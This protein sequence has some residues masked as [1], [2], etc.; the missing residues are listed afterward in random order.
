[1][2]LFSYSGHGLFGP[3]LP[4][5]TTCTGGS[6]GAERTSAREQHTS[7]ELAGVRTNI[8]RGLLTGSDPGV[9]TCGA[10]GSTGVAEGRRGR[11]GASFHGM[12][13]RRPDKAMTRDRLSLSVIVAMSCCLLLAGCGAGDSAGT[14]LSSAH[15]TTTTTTMP[16][17]PPAHCCQAPDD[18]RRRRLA[19]G[20]PRPRPRV[21]D[22]LQPPCAH[23]A[24]LARRQRARPS[25]TSTTGLRSS[26]VRLSEYHPQV[27]TIL[28]GGN[29]AQNFLVDNEPVVFGTA[30]WH[31][32]YSQ[33]VAL[34]MKETLKAGAKMLWV[35]LPIMQ[36]P[37]P[38]RPPC[39]CSA[40]DLQGTG[41]GRHPGV[42]F[43]PDL[44]ALL[45][46]PGS[47][48]RLPHQQLRPDGARTGL[49]TASTSPRRAAA[50]SS[51]SRR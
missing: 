6:T 44:E 2:I 38:S 37:T 49:Q 43:C 35:G 48:H 25:R 42:I 16:P 39:R 22:G 12:P 40:R 14:S 30:Q 11:H 34:M 46:R 4:M 5:T 8:G 21:H 15:S 26:G 41:V 13:A 3:R 24:G 45:E 20:G 29:D 47:V 31:T 36:D 32:I 23:R 10:R 9:A 51:P 33:R 1:M 17:P 28:I 27:V 18:P 50:T 19:R 7:G